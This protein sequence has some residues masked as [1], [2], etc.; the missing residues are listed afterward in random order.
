MSDFL[1]KAIDPNQYDNLDWTK[2]GDSTS[3]TR[4]FFQ[5]ILMKR[6]NSLEGVRVLDVGSGVGQLYSFFNKLAAKEILG[7]EPSLKNVEKSKKLNPDFVV[8]QETLESFSTDKK[9]DAIFVVLVLEHVE[10]LEEAFVKLRDILNDNGR[11]YLLV[12]DAKHAIRSRHDYDIEYDEIKPGVY[13]VKTKRHSGVMYD[14]VREPNVYM[15]AAESAG[16]ALVEH[17]PQ[18]PD[19]ELIDDMQ[20]YEEFKDA[21]IVHLMMFKKG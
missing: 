16:L 5:R 8:Q 11:I 7:I 12:G 15:S 17:A 1:Q 20:K 3:P 4:T 19:K 18:T 6:I 2:D 21:P 14:L 9:F 10:N 13:G